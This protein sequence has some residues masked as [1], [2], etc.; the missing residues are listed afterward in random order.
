MA[1]TLT[2]STITHK[3]RGLVRIQASFTTDA[4]GD[5]TVGV[6]GAAYGKVV[7]VYFD[8]G[9]LDT[10]ADITLRDQRTGFAILTLTNAGTA[11]RIIRPTVNL[12]LQD[13]AAV[14]AAATSTDVYRDLFV[15]GKLSLVVAQGGNAKS[16]KLDIVV[17]EG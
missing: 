8:A 15:A 17:D 5:V 2:P 7:A 4:S 1:G 10:G 16:G 12:S 13:G 14:A 3:S 6:I 11:D 9:D